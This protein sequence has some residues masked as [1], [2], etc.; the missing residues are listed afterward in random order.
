[1][2][3]KR[4]EHLLNIIN[5]KCDKGSFKVLTLDEI[6]LSFPEKFGA[7][8]QLIRQMTDSL[9]ASGYVAVMFDGEDEICIAPT[10][11]GREHFEYECNYQNTLS[12]SKW[13]FR[14]YLYLFLTV[15][16]ANIAT[17]FF[18]F[19]ARWLNVIS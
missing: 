8:K 10:P 19:L 14:D 12:V 2:L 1:M 3:D 15:F 6:L 9:K 11:K 4:S 18:L 7:D 5:R 13:T 17:L 16:T